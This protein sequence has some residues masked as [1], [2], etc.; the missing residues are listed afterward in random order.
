MLYKQSIASNCARTFLSV[1]IL[2]TRHSHPPALGV[3]RQ[4]TWIASGD[5][6]ICEEGAVGMAE[7]SGQR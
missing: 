6:S 4:R 5:L 7:V 1:K 3:Y 2:Y